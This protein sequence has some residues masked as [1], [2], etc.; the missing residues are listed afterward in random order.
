[1]VFP[2]RTLVRSQSMSKYT[3]GPGEG[4]STVVLLNGHVA[5]CLLHINVGTNTLVLLSALAREAS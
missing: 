1:M 2:G 4:L 3:G 5:S